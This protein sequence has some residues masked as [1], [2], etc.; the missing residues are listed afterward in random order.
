MLPILRRILVRIQDALW[1]A[2]SLSVPLNATLNAGQKT[3][4]MGALFNA[5]SLTPTR[6]SYCFGPI[7]QVIFTKG[8]ITKRLNFFLI[9][10]GTS[11]VVFTFLNNWIICKAGYNYQKRY[12][13]EKC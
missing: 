6:Q 5:T 13:D 12:D 4:R 11:M 2:Y 9:A 8:R 1:G 3:S 10:P 7:F